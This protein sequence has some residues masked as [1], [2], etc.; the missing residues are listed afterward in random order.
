MS[1][2]RKNDTIIEG[3]YYDPD[4]LRRKTRRHK[5]TAAPALQAMYP[6]TTRRRNRSSPRVMT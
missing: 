2:K 6:S 3:E 5:S 1:E 4:L